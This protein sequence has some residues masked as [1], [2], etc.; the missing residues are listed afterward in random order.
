MPKGQF[1]IRS[2]VFKN[3]PERLALL[4][5]RALACGQ[6]QI[7]ADPPQPKGRVATKIRAMRFGVAFLLFMRWYG[8]GMRI[9]EI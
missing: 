7:D 9:R 4:C 3:S 1:P 5:V 2:M 8:L 6:T